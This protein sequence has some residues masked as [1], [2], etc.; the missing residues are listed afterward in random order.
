LRDNPGTWL[1]F[2]DLVFIDP[3]GTGYSRAL[4]TGDEAR[5]RLYSVDGDIETLAQ[6]VRR[7]LDRADRTAS[8]KFILGESYGGF[9]APLLARQLQHDG[10][11]GVSGLVMLSPA[12]DFGGRSTA[13]DP[14]YYAI[15]LPSMTGAALAARQAVTRADLAAAEGYAAGEYVTD[16][17]RGVN[18]TEAVARAS[19]RVARLIGL[20]PQLVLRYKA[21]IDMDVFLHERDRAQARVGSPYDPTITSPDPFPLEG[22]SD[23][24]EPVVQALLAPITSAMVAIYNEQLHWR[25]DTP[26]RL[27]NDAVFH[28]W[29]WGRRMYGGAQAM[30]SLRLAMA[31]DPTLR[32]LIAHGLFDLVTP[33]FG[34]VLILRQV[35]PLGAPDRITLK[36]YAGGH[37]FYIGDVSRAAFREDARALIAGP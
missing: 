34:N 28:N 13:L 5:R 36:T 2:T 3:P 4:L 10:G 27:S 20:D 6:V 7:W 21:R 18:D 30:T 8:P 37:M 19:E 17:L 12:L 25:P 26:Y 35:P 29:D 15:R 22:V 16:L 9:R 33:Y 31:L 14:L 1:G 11:V 24:D 23:Y 32:V